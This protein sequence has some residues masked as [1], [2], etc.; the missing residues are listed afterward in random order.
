[1]RETDYDRVTLAEIQG[2]PDVA[3]GERLLRYY[4]ALW[5]ELTRA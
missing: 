5:T 4:K 3:S 2:A 1:M